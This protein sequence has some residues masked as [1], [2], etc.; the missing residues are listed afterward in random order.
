MMDQARLGGLFGVL[1]VLAAIWCAL[2]ALGKQ[3]LGA[4]AELRQ[5]HE[6]HEGHARQQQAGLDDL[7][8]GGGRHAAEQHVDHH[9]RADDDHGHPVFQ[10]EQQLDELARA[11]HL[12]DQVEGHHHQRA[13]SREGA[14]RRLLEA[15][16]RHVG[17]GELAQV[18]QALGH[19]EGDDG[20]AHQEADGVDQAVV[21][22]GHHGRRNAQERG[23]RHVVAGNRQAVLE[24]GDAAAAV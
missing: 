11:D 19:Q 4:E 7:H 16:A 24:A 1:P 18:A 17:K 9:Q 8:P 15:V 22:G 5:H 20:P 2:H 6:G 23:R 3:R 21:A 10:A 14:D 13:R 12:C